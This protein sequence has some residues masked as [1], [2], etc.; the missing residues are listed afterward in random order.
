MSEVLIP[1]PFCG[2]QEAL[3]FTGLNIGNSGGYRH[4]YCDPSMA[5]CGAVGRSVH[6]KRVQEE[7]EPEAAR[8]WNTRAPN[9][10]SCV[11]C[12]VRAGEVTFPPMDLNLLVCKICQAK[13]HQ[14]IDGLCMACHSKKINE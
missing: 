6:F 10:E 14:T 3:R 12:A 2:E 13:T 5:G 8:L 1:C 11:T 4:V 9:T 7:A